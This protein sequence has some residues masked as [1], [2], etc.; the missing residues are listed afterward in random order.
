LICGPVVWLKAK[1]FT[2]FRHGVGDTPLRNNADARLLWNSAFS[3]LIRTA[4]CHSV[5]A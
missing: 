4:I 5:I 3:G 2:P 1:S